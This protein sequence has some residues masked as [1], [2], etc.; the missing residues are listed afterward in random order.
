MGHVQERGVRRQGGMLC[1]AAPAL[2]VDVDRDAP[3]PEDVEV[4]R[5]P[6]AALAVY[7]TVPSFVRDG[8]REDVDVHGE[9]RRDGPCHVPDPIE[10]AGHVLVVNETSERPVDVTAAQVDRH[11]QRARVEGEA[12]RV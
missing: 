10:R 5:R 4:R 3:P 6:E 2:H 8:R 7:G 12:G 1:R 9:R 11:A